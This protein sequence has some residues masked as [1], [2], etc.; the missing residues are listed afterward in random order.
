MICEELNLIERDPKDEA[1]VRE[2]VVRGHGLDD[3]VSRLR[4]LHLKKLDEGVCV[5]DLE[6]V[7]IS[8]VLQ[9]LDHQIKIRSTTFLKVGRV[10]VDVLH[11]LTTSK[12]LRLF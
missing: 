10:V 9:I 11:F 4:S 3:G 5:G 12:V 7:S 1:C 6:V 2:E 8:E